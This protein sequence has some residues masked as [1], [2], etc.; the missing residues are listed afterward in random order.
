MPGR[1]HS[2]ENSSPALPNTVVLICIG[3]MAFVVRPTFRCMCHVIVLLRAD[4]EKE[5]GNYALRKS[6]QLYESWVQQA[7][8]IIK[9]SRAHKAAAKASESANFVEAIKC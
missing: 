3:W 7:G 5:A 8:G 2:T 6:S 9:G 1:K 4:F